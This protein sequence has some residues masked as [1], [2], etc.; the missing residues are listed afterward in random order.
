[1]QITK[2]NQTV[3]SF[4]ANKIEN[5]L[6]KCFHQVGK[7]DAKNEAERFKS[8][9]L[10]ELKYSS[11]IYEGLYLHQVSIEQIQNIVEKILLNNDEYS[12][13]EEYARYRKE[14]EII[15]N[16]KSKISNEVKQAFAE[17]KKYFP[18]I[19]SEIQFYDKMARYNHEKHRRETWKE[20]I[21]ERV[22]P[23][24]RHFSDNKLSEEVYSLL[25]ENIL[26]TKATPSFRL[27]AMAGEAAIRDNTCIYNC[28]FL[29]PDRLQFFAEDLYISMCGTGDGFSVEDYYISQLPFVKYQTGEVVHYVFEDNTESWCDG[30]VFNIINLLEGKDVT[31]DTSKIRKEGSIL[32]VKGG[33]SSGPKPLINSLKIVRDIILNAQGRRLFSDEN[34]D[35]VCVGGDCAIAGGMRR[36]AKI[37]ICDFGDP[38]MR[39]F[40]N[41]ENTKDK[42]WR[43]NTN[44]SE[45]FA[46]IYTQEEIDEF[47]DNMHNSGRGEN[48]IFSRINAVL[49]APERRIKYWENILGYK[50]TLENAY[51]SSLILKIG[52]NPC[53]EIFLRTF[54]NLSIAVARAGD[55]F[56]TLSEKVKIA[57]ILGTIQSC[58]THFPYLN[59]EWER[60]SKEERLLGVDIIGQAD[61]G[62]L[63]LEWQAKLRQIVIDTN[64]E[65]ANILGIE[66]S[67]ATTCVKPGG[68]SGAFLQASSS[69]SKHKHK[70]SLRN[71]E[72]NIFTPIF[73]VLKHSKVPGFPKPGYEHNTYI[74]SI[75]QKAPDGALIQE[76]DTLAEQLDYWLQIKQNYTEHN[77]SCT[78][79]YALD[80]LPYLKKWI[81]EHQHVIGG[82][83]FF[84]KVDWKFDYLPIE[85][86]SKE[87]YEQRVAELPEIDWEL[88]AVFE[89][90]D[91]TTASKEFACA[92][93]NCSWG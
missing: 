41:P 68:N 84:P 71:I 12:A 22:M 36:T 93:D 64:I 81:F 17:S 32:K 31:Y 86:I 78:L 4:D 29:V 53:G 47:V 43:Y 91:Q 76:N 87:E 20:M 79:Y 52:T 21:Q 62:F 33:R 19:L 6:F 13:Y 75:P 42:P 69:I 3:Q 45:A 82:L 39:A 66:Q 48:G 40:K 37:C 25:E 77:P 74:F 27:L 90:D 5:A 92:G 15:R 89:T 30:W 49:N 9:V 35:I 18:N 63:P 54:C 50:L 14:R 61:I 57:A 80:E 7:K 67:M 28:S 16:L 23:C 34:A 85:K 2:R 60:I 11:G 73:K 65:F 44:V 88:L 83:T 51:I 46:R 59:E 24:L 38:R 72:V 55:V 1:M 70:W 10:D 8:L 58:A 26:A 56:G